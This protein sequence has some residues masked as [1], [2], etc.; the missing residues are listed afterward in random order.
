M[1]SIALARDSKGLGVLVLFF[2]VPQS[3]LQ[4]KSHI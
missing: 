1:R 2:A 4:H 3:P